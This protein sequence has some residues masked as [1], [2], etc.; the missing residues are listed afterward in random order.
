MLK[1]SLIVGMPIVA[2][3]SAAKRRGVRTSE[4]TLDNRDL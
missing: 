4:R 3:S 2:F 1:S